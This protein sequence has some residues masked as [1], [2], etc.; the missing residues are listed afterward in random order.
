[1][2]ISNGSTV[3]VVRQEVRWAQ[4]G[5]T[6]C[7]AGAQGKVV[8]FLSGK[9]YARVKFGQNEPVSCQVSNLKLAS[10]G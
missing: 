6:W 9:K 7:A 2:P 3:E 5:R 10:A 8:G 4:M 1:M